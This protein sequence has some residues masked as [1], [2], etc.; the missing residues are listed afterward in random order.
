MICSLLCPWN[1]PGKNTRVGCHSL[2]QGIFPTQVSNPGL[3]HCR[4]ILYRLSH[5]GTPI[6][7]KEA[8]RNG[9][10]KLS[11]KMAQLFALQMGNTPKHILPQPPRCSQWPWTWHHSSGYLSPPASLPCSPTYGCFTG[12]HQTLA[13]KSSPQSQ[14]LWEPSQRRWGIRLK[15]CRG[16]CQLRPQLFSCCFRSNEALRWLC[17]FWE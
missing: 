15:G 6:T 11:G 16:W 3:L 5:Q 10:W 2:L 8:L 7:S 12:S 4:W 1:S 13:H 17:S 9:K 14:L